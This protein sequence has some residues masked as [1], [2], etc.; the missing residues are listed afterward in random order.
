MAT[1]QPTVGALESCK[2]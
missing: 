2:N 1:P